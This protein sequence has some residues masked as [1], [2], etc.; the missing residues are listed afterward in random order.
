MLG[1]MFPLCLGPVDPAFKDILMYIFR[2][3]ISHIPFY[4]LLGADCY[5][6][7]NDLGAGARAKEVKKNSMATRPGK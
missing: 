7:I 5:K 1:P 6:G 3:V 2:R 4:S